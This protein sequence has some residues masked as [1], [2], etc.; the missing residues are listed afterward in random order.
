VRTIAGLWIGQAAHDLRFAIRMYR[1]NAGFCTAAVLTLAIGI[2][3]NVANSTVVNA[4]L[5]RP[6]PYDRSDRL[7]H[8]VENGAVQDGSTP[9]IRPVPAFDLGTLAAF[10]RETKTLSHAR[11]SVQQIVQ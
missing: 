11:V 4:V 2:G 9:V 10:R 1:R 7:V 6:L 8:I 3:A 5:L